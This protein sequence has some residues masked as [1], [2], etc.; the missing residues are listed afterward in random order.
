MQEILDKLNRVRG[1][2]G[3]LVI[4]PDGL[5]MVT[6]LRQGS[7]ESGIAAAL[8][9]LIDNAT[10]LCGH[11]GFGKSRALQALGAQGGL[12]LMPAGPAFLAIVMDPTANLA[13]LQLEARPFAERISQRLSL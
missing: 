11:L 7:D 1:V 10:R 4:S 8:S 6:A 3:S 5:P 12:L 9:S 13:L 2:G